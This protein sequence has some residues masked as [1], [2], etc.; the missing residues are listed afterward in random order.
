MNYQEI[1]TLISSVGFPIAA[2]V[3]LFIVMFKIIVPL[4]NNIQAL[5]KAVENLIVFIEKGEKENE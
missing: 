1:T 2:Y 5:T 4:S 3:A